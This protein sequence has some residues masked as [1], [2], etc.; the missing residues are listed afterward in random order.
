LIA[1]FIK[2]IIKNETFNAMIASMDLV[3]RHYNY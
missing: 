1:I 3:M 2:D